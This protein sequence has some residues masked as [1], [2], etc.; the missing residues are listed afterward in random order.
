MDVETD[1]DF[2]AL[3]QDKILPRLPEIMSELGPD[4]SANIVRQVL[5]DGNSTIVI[6]I[7]TPHEYHRNI[8]K[9][10]WL[11]IGKICQE[12]GQAPI[13]TSF[14]CGRLSLLAGARQSSFDLNNHESTISQTE[15]PHQWRW[16]QFPGMGASLGIRGSDEIHA[17]SGGY[18]W[19][20]GKSYMLLSNHLVQDAI[21]ERNPQHLRTGS[22]L[23][24]TSPSAAD[25]EDLKDD[26][27]E[28]ISWYEAEINAWVVESQLGDIRLEDLARINLP[29]IIKSQLHQLEQL[30][31]YAQE[32]DREDEGDFILGEI[33]ARCGQPRARV[34]SNGRPTFRVMDWALC[35]VDEERMGHNRHRFRRDPFSG[36]VDYTWT[37]SDFKGAG[38]LCQE[39]GPV[40]GG[41]R[42]HFYGATSGFVSAQVSPTEA[43]INFHGKF[44]TECLLVEVSAGQQYSEDHRGDSGAWII[45]DDGNLLIGMLWAE[46]DFCLY[47]TPIGDVFDNI[48]RQCSAREVCLPPHFDSYGPS[49]GIVP[50]S[51]RKKK[52]SNRRPPVSRNL[53]SQDSYGLPTVTLPR[54]EF[55]AQMPLEKSDQSQ[56][57]VGARRETNPL[58]PSAL[59]ALT[60]SRSSPSISDLDCPSPCPEE[61]S[62]VKIVSE[63]DPSQ[64]WES[65]SVSN[66]GVTEPPVKTIATK[67]ET[68]LSNLLPKTSII[69]A[70]TFP[71]A[72]IPCRS[73]PVSKHSLDYILDQTFATKL[74]I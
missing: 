57:S 22:P 60:H 67:L 50:V 70:T 11:S 27:L 63:A 13:Q 5:S 74:T 28:R 43:G 20:D 34:G 15:L 68:N 32:L 48:R 9:D 52:R 17:T 62:Q 66:V 30:R 26:L 19:K 46:R 37:G 51:G 69:K 49:N 33:K 41:A 45:Q 36:L 64:I 42:V 59:P 21:R 39:T 6:R 18:I 16:W 71:L 8:R 2:I 3:W 61:E 58:S 56:T 10:V 73:M 44:T 53:P 4:Y 14:S 25:V 1:K 38:N 72:R 55:A 40:I 35:E 31:T 29:D 23:Q 54:A 12:H 24:V 65:E 47:F 7:Q